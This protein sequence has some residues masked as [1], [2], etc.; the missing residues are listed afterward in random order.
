MSFAS[1][2]EKSAK[3]A[4]LIKKIVET[5]QTTNYDDPNSWYPELDK[6]GNGFAIIRFLSPAEGESIPW[7]KV[8]SHSFKNSA[9]KWFVENCPTTLE[10]DCPVCTANS[11]AWNESD[12]DASPGRKLARDRKRK[13]H[14]YANIYVVKDPKNPQNEGKVFKFR[15]GKSIQD[16]ILNAI[17]PPEGGDPDVVAID[18]T[19]FWRGANFRLKIKKKDGYTNYDDS[20]F[21]S[22]TPLLEGN[23]KKLQEVYSQLFPLQ[24]YLD[25]KN[26][27]SPEEME[28]KFKNHSMISTSVSRAA[29]EVPVHTVDTDSKKKTPKVAKKVVEDE[30]E[31]TDSTPHEDDLQDALK[32]FKE[33]AE[34]N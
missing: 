20:T 17:T 33:L 19:D 34:D 26:F 14:Y 2:K 3:S 22:P 10:K 27:L 16:K 1:L 5:Q 30:V 8:Y 24:P 29:D 15:Y 11:K 12:N 6:A 32:M 18:P 4:D 28:K 31:S 7:V 21:D 13:V 23:E 25:P 9:G